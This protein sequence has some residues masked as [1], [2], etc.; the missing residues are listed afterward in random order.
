MPIT[1]SRANLILSLFDKYYTRVFCFARKSLPA[2]QAEDI[3][4]EV[5]SRMLQLKHLEEIDVSISYL[6]KTADNLIKRR[7]NRGQRFKRYVDTVKTGVRP[8]PRTINKEHVCPETRSDLEARLDRLTD[9]ERD[10]VR[11]VICQGM[12]YQEAAAAMGVPVSTV[13]NWKYRGLQKLKE[14][15][16]DST[17]DVEADVAE[18]LWN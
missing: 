4:Q 3:T 15:V 5:F 2:E 16:L 10:T 18:Q 8:S 11:M 12:S 14:D 17:I 6:I 1:Q 13:N 9:A 7:W